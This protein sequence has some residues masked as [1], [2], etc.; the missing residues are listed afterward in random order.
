MASL[1][2][3]NLITK[4]CRSFFRFLKPNPKSPITVNKLFLLIV[5]VFVQFSEGTAREGT[6]SMVR[7]FSNPFQDLRSD[8]FVNMTGHERLIRERLMHVVETVDE[9]Q[10]RSEKAMDGGL[11]VGSAGL[12]YM[13]LHLAG[14]PTFREQR[15]GLL[16]KAEEWIK[17]SLVFYSSSRYRPDATDACAFILGSCGAWAVGAVIAHHLGDRETAGRRL[18]EFQ[19]GAT[20]CLP[21]DYFRHGGDE[22]LVGRAGYLLGCRWL[23]SQLGQEPINQKHRFA[24]LDVMVESGM[25]Y[26]KN[27]KSFIPLMYSYY[28]TEYLGAAHGL[29]GI[30]FVMLQNQDWLAQSPHKDVVRAAMDAFMNLQTEEG[31]FPC[32]MDDLVGRRNRR[33]EDELVHWCHGA[34]GAVYCVAKAYLTWNDEKYLKSL[35]RAADLVWEKGLLL[36]GPGI[37]HGV[38]GNAEVFLLLYRLTK[39]QKYLHRALKFQEFLFSEDMKRARTPD[40]PYSLYEGLAGT[41][42]FLGDMLHPD[43][44]HFP[45]MDVKTGSP[46]SKRG[47]REREKTDARKNPNARGGQVEVEVWNS[48]IVVPED[49]NFYDTYQLVGQKVKKTR[50]TVPD[51]TINADTFARAHGWYFPNPY[52]DYGT[53][54]TSSLSSSLQ[55]TRAKIRERLKGMVEVIESKLPR[56]EDAMDGALYTGSSGAGYMYLHISTAPSFHAEKQALLE[57]G[58][59]WIERSL[60]FFT[61]KRYRADITD[62]CGFLLGSSGVWAVGAAIAHELDEHF[63]RVAESR[64]SE[65]ATTTLRDSKKVDSRLARFAKGATKCLPI[66]F[67]RPGGDEMLVGRA[68][69]LIGVKWLSV[70]LDREVIPRNIRYPLLDAVVKS[71]IRYSRKNNSS[72][73][74]MYSYY[75][76][77]YLGAAHGLAGILFALLI[78]DDWF[79]QSMHQKTKV[80][81]WHTMFFL[82]VPC[83]S[84]IR[85]SVD[86]LVSMQTEEGNWRVYL[87][88]EARSRS[89]AKEPTKIQW[90]HGA[91]G[92]VFCL[93]KAY[94]VWGDEK[95]LNSLRKAADLTWEKGLLWKGPGLCHGVAGNAEV[96]LL[97]YRLTKEEKYLYRAMKFQEFL[98]SSEIRRARTP[99]TPYSLYEGL[100]G[101][102]C[103]LVDLLHPEEA[104][105]PFMNVFS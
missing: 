52:S 34:P 102:A 71:G 8:A 97:L 101:T 11:Y 59:G 5:P 56:D 76:T 24:L 4:S 10:P 7:Y 23:A 80:Y 95:Y 82:S 61:S 27:H 58:E 100:A 85:R 17:P 18:R 38:A 68:G 50:S 55:K 99:D 31:N 72:V 87:D 75:G 104:R 64:K 94:L 15:R 92:I 89:K 103:F 43:L 46:F 93:A 60:A 91:P 32:A 84:V 3:K 79:R 62:S 65:N 78:H 47:G 105:F 54:S 51:V 45:F 96:F 20:A 22:M 73:P 98:F 57:R 16:E 83:G 1:C 69:Y 21:I 48:T 14:L 35:R 74:L 77:E 19:K 70:Q 66:D 90:C 30:L 2:H 63:G 49:L 12:A 29:C 86:V 40:T 36:K 13:Y 33:P 88:E 26:A 44:A 81:K 53:G 25:R 42:C 28:G 41:A 37:C 67:F 9:K 39:E 6:S